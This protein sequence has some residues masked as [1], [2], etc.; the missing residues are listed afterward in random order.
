[1]ALDT[2]KEVGVVGR[3]GRVAHDSVHWHLFLAHVTQV[4]CLGSVR[5]ETQREQRC[6]WKKHRIKTRRTVNSQFGQFS[7]SVEVMLL[8]P[9]SMWGKKQNASCDVSLTVFI[10]KKALTYV[11]FLTGRTNKAYVRESPC[12]Q[13]TW[14]CD[15]G[16]KLRI[17]NIEER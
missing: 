9:N 8:N 15:I 10:Y 5:A 14:S 2:Y 7:L 1:M 16:I 11:Q 13:R 6:G 17:N 4:K 12:R 3:G